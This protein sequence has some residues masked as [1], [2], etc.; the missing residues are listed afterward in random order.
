MPLAEMSRPTKSS[1]ASCSQSTCCSF[2][3]TSSSGALVSYFTPE[4][5]RRSE[6]ESVVWRAASSMAVN[7]SAR[8]VGRAVTPPPPPAARQP[9]Q[10][11]EEAAHLLAAALARH[12]LELRGVHTQRQHA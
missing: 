9:A 8:R 5:T 2:S 11:D 3:S 7:C 10:L 6:V 12:R 1:T 4:S